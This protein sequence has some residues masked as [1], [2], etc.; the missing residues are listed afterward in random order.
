MFPGHDKLCNGRH[1]GEVWNH[2]LAQQTPEILPSGF[3]FWQIVPINA[4]GNVFPGENIGRSTSFGDLEH[5]TRSYA[6]LNRDRWIQN[7]EC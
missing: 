3:P 6:D 2:R 4:N 5:Q 1:G 7:P